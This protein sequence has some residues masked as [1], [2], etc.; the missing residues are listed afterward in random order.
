MLYNNVLTTGAGSSGWRKVTARFTIPP[1]GSTIT[2]G[3]SLYGSGVAYFDDASLT[4][5][6]HSQ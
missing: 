3:T 4:K 1:G 5:T 2:L 6:G